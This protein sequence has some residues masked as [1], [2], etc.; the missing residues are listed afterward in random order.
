MKHMDMFSITER[1]RRWSLV[2]FCLLT[3]G[4]LV[5]CPVD[6]DLDGY[7][8]DVD[9]DDND[10]L[11]Y[12][13]AEEL[14]DIKDNNCNGF[15]DEPPKDFFR[16]DYSMQ[17]AGSAVEWYGEYLYLGAA[18]VLQVFHA[19]AGSEPELIRE[20]EFRD[21]IRE[22]A[23][24]GDTLFL[25]A[26]GD[27]LFALDLSDPADPR[28]AGNVSGLIDVGGLTDVEVIVFGLDA[29]QNRV[30]IANQNLQ[31]KIYG[32]VD[33][34]VFDYDPIT[35]TFNP[36]RTITADI[37]RQINL[38]ESPI[39]VALTEDALGLYVAYGF[40]GP[41]LAI[42]P[43]D[44]YGELTYVVIDDPGAALKN[45]NVG[46]VMDV[47]TTGDTAF[48]AI[49]QYEWNQEVSMLSRISIAGDELIEYP[50]LTELSGSAGGSVDIDGDLL[51]FGLQMIHRFE[52]KTIW[53]F[54]DLL[55]DPPNQ[56]ATGTAMD[57]IYQLSC[58]RGEAYDWIYAADEWGGLEV[59]KVEEPDL[60]LKQRKATGALTEKL[61]LDGDL[62]YSAK[63]GA[64]L[65]VFDEDEPRNEQVAVEWID[66]SDPGCSC[67]GCSCP[68][69]VGVYPP[70]VF[71]H[72]G[73][74]SQDRIV[75]TTGARYDRT[76]L[77]EPFL[78]VFAKTAER[79]VLQYSEAL[80]QTVD[81]D[82][83]GELLLMAGGIEGLRLYQHCPGQTEEV[84]FLAGT[85]TTGGLGVFVNGAAIY[86][87]YLLVNEHNYLNPINF[88]GQ[89]KVFRFKNGALP[90]CPDLPTVTLE[91]IGSLAT[92]RLPR[93]VVI[94]QDRQLLIVG[95]ETKIGRYGAVLQYDLPG[96]DEEITAEMLS[97]METGRIDISAGPMSRIINPSVG[98]M[99]LDGDYLYIADMQNG[100]YKYA[101]VTEKY[102]SFYPAHNGSWVAPTLV[103]SPEGIVPLYDPNSLALAPSGRVMVQE[104]TTGRV[105]ILSQ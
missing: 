18:A 38:T 81:V 62:V 71:V 73:C 17:G 45:I 86:G 21:W 41:K 103:K 65:W 27:G 100:L 4:L 91:Y 3:A 96:P 75:T 12:P 34:I 53:A 98:E 2:G 60:V 47:A 78:M 35:E 90:T 99:I 1:I 43:A 67:T 51:C 46:M 102:V 14:A 101:L 95:C 68:S 50:I 28:P 88:T 85:P 87:D 22:M 57:W 7:D 9:C 6:N 84:R 37:G 19:P 72:G 104:F 97:A 49:T 26:R 56:L 83:D 70:A 11:T 31:A 105:S 54:N 40:L 36:V 48:I 77:S 82:A 76:G 66:L 33:A 10:P 20:I 69:D 23:V 80:G 63:R 29:K 89:L 74:M 59:W 44:A 32:G 94:D 16:D 52:G 93:D 25:A 64:G 5:G 42:P 39:T 61:W 92:D 15:A 55:A 24:S 58:R 8:S 79:L 30:A 13:G